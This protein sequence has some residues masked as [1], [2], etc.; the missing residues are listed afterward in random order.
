MYLIPPNQKNAYLHEVSSIARALQKQPEALWEK[1]PDL[2]HVRNQLLNMMDSAL[3]SAAP[4]ARARMIQLE[5]RQ[6][7]T[8]SLQSSASLGGLDIQALT[9]V[10]GP[11]FKPVVLTHHR[12]LLELVESIP[13]LSEKLTLNGVAEA[14]NWRILS[15]GATHYLTERVVFDCLALHHTETIRTPLS[16]SL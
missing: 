16:T 10:A 14:G 1:I 15:R 2:T 4:E 7:A 6:A 12:E 8:R 9:I 13:D 3:D 5:T 11:A